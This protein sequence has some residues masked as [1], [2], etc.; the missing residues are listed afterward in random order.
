[1]VLFIVFA[2]VGVMLIVF[3]AV[4]RFKKTYTIISGINTSTPERRAKMNLDAICNVVGNTLMA[5]GVLW[6]AAGLLFMIGIV[7]A[8][9]AMFPLFIILM[10]G[11]LLYVQRYDYNNRNESGKV[12]RGVLF[13]A[14][15]AVS[16]VTVVLVGLLITSGMKAPAVTLDGNVMRI[17]STFGCEIGRENI[18]SLELT[19]T[20][21][22]MSRTNGYGMGAYLK[23]AVYSSGLGAGRAYI[24]TDSPPF[25]FI[26]LEDADEKFL[27]V[28]LHSKEQTEALYTKINA[29]AA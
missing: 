27:Y 9:V 19:D 20:V 8:P 16:L 5:G 13:I 28:N 15:G 1:M 21:P 6:I 17:E 3:G 10:L 23:G 26:T 14:A 4:I 12:K 22:P 18:V 25:I 29:W 2:L 7:I 11:A 24:K